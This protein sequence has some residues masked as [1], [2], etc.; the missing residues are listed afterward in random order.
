MY[1]GLC[2]GCIVKNIDIQVC[3]RLGYRC[4]VVLS[5]SCEGNQHQGVYRVVLWLSFEGYKRHLGVHEV[6]L[7]LSCEGYRHLGVHEVKLQC[8]A[9]L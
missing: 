8:I 1:I 7:L 3:I 6:K 4:V 2:Y 5:L 9:I